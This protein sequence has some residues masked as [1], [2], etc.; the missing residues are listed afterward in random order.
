[1]GAVT[2]FHRL[3]ILAIAALLAAGCG[4]NTPISAP[5]ATIT[6]G[7]P[8]AAPSPPAT[9]LATVAVSAPS[10]GVICEPLTED[11]WPPSADFSLRIPFG[12][13]NVFL[14]VTRVSS[15]A[16][17]DEFVEFEA[18]EPYLEEPGRLVGGWHVSLFPESDDDEPDVSISLIAASAVVRISGGGPIQMDATIGTDSELGVPVFLFNVP[19]VRGSAVIDFK[20]EWAD[21]CYTYLAEGPAAFEMIRAAFAARCPSSHRGFAA[22]WTELGE[23]P[24]TAGGVSVVLSA[25]STLG[26][27]SGYAVSAQGNVGYAHWD[28]ESPNAVGEAGGTIRV[29]DGNP[30]L[31]FD[32]LSTEF[33]RRGDIVDWLEGGDFPKRDRIVFRATADPFPDGHLDLLLPNKPG[34]YVASLSYL[35]GSPCARG[36]G[37]GAVGVD[38]E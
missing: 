11:S 37:V 35:W 7:G 32:S 1:M 31:V 33:Y 12:Y 14:D 38:I 19:D 2:G 23:P 8:T 30:D 20:V 22:Y 17:P 18:N 4:A 25:S 28:P 29:G 5:S 10:P 15:I 3:S 6:V 16:R 26:L 21:A 27:W 13:E 36:D 24:P 9:P 34:R